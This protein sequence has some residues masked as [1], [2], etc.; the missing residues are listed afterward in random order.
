MF[1][2]FHDGEAYTPRPGSIDATSFAA[3]IDRHPGRVLPAVEWLTAFKR[4]SLREA[5]VCISFDDNL[6]SQAAVALPVLRERNLTAFWFVYSGP[7]TG[8]AGRLEIYNTFRSEYFADFETFFQAFTS[9]A[10]TQPQADR[11]ERAVAAFPENYLQQYS[12]YSRSER[13]FRYIRDMVLEREQYF[14]LMDQMMER[15]GADR[16]RMAQQLWL[17]REDISQLHH[18]GHVIGLHSHTHPTNMQRLS[19]KEQFEE[20]QTNKQILESV[21]QSP[22]SCMSHPCNSYNRDSLTVLKQLGIEIG[23]RADPH[24]VN[25]TSLELP[26]IDHANYSDYYG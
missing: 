12:F 17:T 6:K 15:Q 8:A 19:N 3:L 11:I 23:F 14:A 2:A 9:F 1:H 21:I 18:S 5:D 20:Y 22:V 4:N 24:L 13:L 25:F 26:R 16:V 7:L 10:K